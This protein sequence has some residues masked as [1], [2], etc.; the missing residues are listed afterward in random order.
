MIA[1][2]KKIKYLRVLK[3]VLSIFTILFFSY[4]CINS[5]ESSVSNTD[6]FWIKQHSNQIEVLFGYEAPPNAFYNSKGEYVGLLVDF[7]KEIELELDVKFK[8]KKFNN[9]A[10]L[11]EYSKTSNNCIIVGVAKTDERDTYLNFTTN[12][13]VNIPY[14]IFTRKDSE[15]NNIDKLK[16]VKTCITKKYAIKNY[17]DN[18]YPEINA[19]EVENNLIG[20]RGV[21]SSLYDAMVINQMYGTYLVDKQGITNLKIAGESGYYNALS[22]GVSKNSIQLF[23]I[24]NKAV[25]QISLER[26]RDIYNKWVYASTGKLT[27]FQKNVLISFIGFVVLL[28]GGLWLW[29]VSLKRVVYK[30]THSIKQSE[31]KYSSI[32]ENSYDAI[33][34][35]FNNKIVL[36]NKKFETLFGYSDKEFLSE[37]FNFLDLFAEE[38]KSQIQTKIFEGIN[39]SKK[40][41]VAEV[42]GVTKNGATLYLEISVSYL[43]YQNGV[44]V[45][46]IIHNVT[47]RK[48]K[49]IEL[50]K[51]KERAEES[52]RLKTA[53]LANM[54]HE[55]RTPMNGI[56]GF[57]NLLE[58]TNITDDQRHEFIEVIKQSGNRMLNTVNDLIDIS[59]IET[60]QMTLSYSK[61]NINERLDNLFN[62]FQLEAEKKGLKL[63]YFK[64]ISNDL[65]FINVDKSK[66]DSILSNLLKNAIKFT[67]KGNIHF[68][69]ELIT[70][71]G[72]TFYKFFVEDTGIGIPNNRLKAIFNRFEQADIEDEEAFQGSGLGLAISKS[73]VTMLRGKIWVESINNQGSKFYFTIPKE[74]EKVLLVDKE[75]KKDCKSNEHMKISKVLIVEDDE[76]SAIYLKQILNKICTEIIH[77]ESGEEAVELCKTF[78]NIDIIFMDIKMKGIG[79]YEATKQIRLFNN[80]VKIMA[81]TAYTM[82]G[83]REKA[84]KAGCNDYIEKP[85]N[86]EIFYNKIKLLLNKN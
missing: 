40:P 16:D 64:Q 42:V 26:K 4:S 5:K 30:K 59:K 11:I 7:L 80:N 18:Y 83:D 54:S 34:I 17:I 66:L 48:N 31:L 71:E 21:S 73:Y 70:K 23:K 75:L 49:E 62:F 69:Y 8:I 46:G 15:I 3:H 9:W 22:V 53:F 82:P 29:L 55:I 86:K 33:F 56:L 25:N 6:K 57:T 1:P 74:K 81:Q 24:I 37:S 65:A 12:S 13:L 2:T 47:E 44:A 19:I 79:G 14:V 36:F 58:M 39:N 27:N 76:I 85:I 60:N 63:T 51:A 77:V 68:G 35:R 20:L 28:I 10:S 43:D 72:I 32:I 38:S 45:Q 61:I 41:F 78:N 52:D 67:K 84:L 50:L